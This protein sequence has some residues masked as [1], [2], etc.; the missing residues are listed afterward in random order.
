MLKTT[1][2]TELRSELSA[3]LKNIS[4]GPVMI[5]SH[6]RP[7]AILVDPDMFDTLMQECELL[8]D[9]LDG[10]RAVAEYKGN[11]SSVIDAEEAF[12]S[13]GC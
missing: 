4:E 2:V 6:S 8:E 12:K 5:M 10:R 11:N 1:T 9:I 7:A 13:L 3:Y